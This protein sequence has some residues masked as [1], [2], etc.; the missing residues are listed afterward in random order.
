M[1]RSRL[2][3][4]LSAL[5]SLWADVAQGQGFRKI[6]GIPR[7]QFRDVVE[8]ADG[9]FFLAG[10]SGQQPA[11]FQLADRVGNPI[12][13]YAM[14]LGGAEPVA[15][16]QVSDGGFVVLA[17]HFADGS[18]SGP[19]RNLLLKIS[20]AGTV[21]WQTPLTND[22]MENGAADLVALPDGGAVVLSSVRTDFFNQ[23]AKLLKINADGSPAWSSEFGL[24]DADEFAVRLL[25]DSDGGFTVGGYGTYGA[26]GEGISDLFLAKTDANGTLLWLKNYP[27]PATQFARDLLRAADG[28]IVLLG[29]TQQ[30]D[31]NQVVVLKT[32][33]AGNELW[34]TAFHPSPRGPEVSPL[35]VFNAVAQDGAGQLHVPI[36][37]YD[38]TSPL[39][40]VD[41]SFLVRLSPG[42][43]VL[44]K[45]GSRREDNTRQIIH[46]QDDKLALTGSVGPKGSFQFSAYLSRLDLEGELYGN[47]INGSLYRDLNDD[48]LRQP[49]EPALPNFSVRGKNAAGETFFT[50]TNAAGDYSLLVSEGTFDITAEALFGL[51]ENWGACDTPAVAVAGLNVAVNAPAIG[52]RS[53][54]TCPQMM[55]TLGAG[56]LRRC[57]TARFLVNYCNAG[58]A[59]ASGTY[60]VLTADPNLEFLSSSLPLS[61]QVGQ[62]FRFDLGN[63]VPGECGSF[64]ADFKVACDVPLGAVLCMEAHIFPDTFCPPPGAADWDGSRLAVDGACDGEVKFTLKNVGL[65]DM[66]EAVEYVIIEDQIIFMQSAVQLGAGKDTVLSIAGTPNGKSYHLSTEQTK[67]YPGKSSPSATVQGCGGGGGENLLL[68]LPQNQDDY[69]ATY[70]AEVRGSFDPN[71]KQGFPT[72]WQEQHLIEKNQPLDYLI[73]FQNTGNDTAFLVVLRDTLSPL[74][75]AG[76]VRPGPGSHPYQFDLSDEGVLTFRF[77]NILLPDSNVNEVASHGYVRFRV[78]QQPDLPLGSRIENR[79]AIYFD[80]NEAVITNTTFHTIGERLLSFAVDRPTDLLGLNV[81]PNPMTDEAIFR[82]QTPPASGADLRLALSDATGRIVRDEM[83]TLPE[84]RFQRRG[85]PP[86]LYFFSVKKDGAVVASGRVVVR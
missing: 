76:T 24:P 58:A 54:S 19:L 37:L 2:F 15:A 48:C 30:A 46:T 84:H 11:L 82:F 25:A 34:F 7:A 72:G 27:K 47:F 33:A 16:C 56:I 61:G 20:P 5:L 42:G 18:G 68:Q 4:I 52:V 41:S 74:L 62:E 59:D 53:L 36:L 26:A 55:L 32:D 77:P 60:V 86:G 39:G 70:C 35:L 21:Q 6:Y 81:R 1:V 17:E 3:L 28:G 40:G 23:N 80:F 83:F 22:N 57:F 14:N 79:A 67:G 75:A 31:P 64:S 50:Q 69:T 44:S 10:I 8:T 12:W 38:F 66:S 63:A 45:K 49:N 73:R 29:E 85:L 43:E 9:S 71:D 78:E 51:A 65:S 13:S